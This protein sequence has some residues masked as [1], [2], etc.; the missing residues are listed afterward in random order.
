MRINVESCRRL[1][2][3][4]RGRQVMV[5]GD[6]MLDEHIWGSVSRV[7][8]EAPVLV[9]DVNSPPSDNRPGGAANVANNVVA[10]GGS[11]AVVGVVGD[12]EG[13]RLLLE[14]LARAGADASR[15]VRDSDRLTTRKTRIWASH[16]QQ[17]VRVDLETK[18][19]VTGRVLRLISDSVRAGSAA[20]DAVLLSDYD[21]GVLTRDV[22]RAALDAAAERGIPVVANPKP[23]NVHN[24][25]GASVVTLNQIEASAASSIDISDR[26]DAEKAA[27]KILDNSEIGALIITRGSHGLSVFRKA[28]EPFHVPAIQSEV[29]D[30]AGAGDTVVAALAMALACGADVNQA[31]VI[32]NCAGGAVVRKVGVATTSIEEIDAL[33]R[34]LES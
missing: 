22:A 29:Y 20:A 24:F 17:I 32:A 30:V 1:L 16:R 8:P 28:A 34:S 25:A 13:G 9:V 5:V 3:R 7:S 18:K 4:F 2:Q 10:L 11:A 15:V 14:S 19:K 27:A 21:K 31:A 33:L 6:L 12:D 23:R 26:A